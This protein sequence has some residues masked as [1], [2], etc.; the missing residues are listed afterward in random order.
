MARICQ[1]RI[2]CPLSV[3]QLPSPQDS[4][5]SIR[6]ARSNLIAVARVRATFQVIDEV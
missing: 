4:E 1:Q 2:L 3:E 6:P 5:G